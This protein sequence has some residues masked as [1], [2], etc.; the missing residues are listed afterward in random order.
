MR[1]PQRILLLLVVALVATTSAALA[2][3]RADAKAHYSAGVKAY[4]TGDYKVAIKEFSAAQQLLP[5]DL[6]NY[7]LALC[8]DK[9]GDAEPAVQYYREYLTKVPSADKRAEIEASIARLESAAKSAAAKKADEQKKLDDAKKA[10]AAKK[11]DDAAKK[12]P[13]LDAKQ[14]DAAAAAPVSSVP[15]YGAGAAVGAGAAGAGA[16]GAV[17]ASASGTPATGQVVSTGDAQLD[18]VQRVDISAMRDQRFGSGTSGVVDPR[19]G[20][21]NVGANGA[22]AAG[23]PQPNGMAPPRSTDPSA[24]APGTA[25]MA[26]GAPPP[27]GVANGANPNGPNG[28]AGGPPP[29]NEPAPVE[30]PVYKKWWFWAVVAVSAYVVIE[31]AT[32]DSS[33]PRTGRELPM[34]G[35]PGPVQ[36]GGFTLLRF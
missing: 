16:T 13:V 2:D 9:L 17:G 3:D 19:A 5:A 10:E 6:N 30:T 12:P 7:N 28:P 25:A 14:D 15:A 11:A 33:N 8:Y 4:S 36:S 29:T 26:N 35:R 32:Q 23:G 34:P 22:V 21:Q 24:P 20:S 31:I 27:N 18:R 1:Q